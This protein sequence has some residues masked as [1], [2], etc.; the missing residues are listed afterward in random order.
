MIFHFENH[1]HHNIYVCISLSLNLSSN[2]IVWLT[3]S[4]LIVWT[5]ENNQIF[6]FSSNRDHGSLKKQTKNV[7]NISYRWSLKK[8]Q[9]QNNIEVIKYTVNILVH[10]E[11]AHIVSCNV[12]IEINA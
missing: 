2:D 11:K 5:N 6:F 10:F 3:I 7:T 12:K 1:V 8:Q 9:Q 4:L